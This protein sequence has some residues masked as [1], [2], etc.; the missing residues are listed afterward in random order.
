M[1][2]GAHIAR[3]VLLAAGLTLAGCGGPG[4]GGAGPA[5]TAAGAPAAATPAKT[6]APLASASPGAGYKDDYGY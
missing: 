5:A 2:I 6:V 1:K 3:T 4:S